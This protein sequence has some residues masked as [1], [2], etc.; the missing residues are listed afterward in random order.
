MMYKVCLHKSPRL[1]QRHL[2]LIPKSPVP[3]VYQIEINPDEPRL[4]A[5]STL[6]ERDSTERSYLSPSLFCSLTK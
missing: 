5:L 2:C 6:Y 4:L 1:L 3:P